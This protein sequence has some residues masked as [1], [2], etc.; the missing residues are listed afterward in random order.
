MKKQK[1]RST[2]MDLLSMIENSP[3]D[4]YSFFSFDD[5]KNVPENSDCTIH[6]NFRTGIDR[7][8]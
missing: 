7:W 2:Q 4:D 5:G 3:F 8:I 1:Q 6:N